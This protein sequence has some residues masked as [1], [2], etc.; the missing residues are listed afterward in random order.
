MKKL[1]QQEE[2]CYE[3]LNELQDVLCRYVPKFQGVLTC[4]DEDESEGENI[5]F[6]YY[7]M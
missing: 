1:C 7:N 6:F 5:T 2:K 4:G 3:R